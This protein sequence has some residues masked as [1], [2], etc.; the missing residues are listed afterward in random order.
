MRIWELPGE[1][2]HRGAQISP[3]G[4]IELQELAV[5]GRD[6]HPGPEHT[7]WLGR[8]DAG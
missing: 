5:Y 8:A 6:L 3:L 4:Q 2:A 1:L 7:G